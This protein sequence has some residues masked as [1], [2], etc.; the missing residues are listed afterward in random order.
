MND[1]KQLNY[2]LV[3]WKN[4]FRSFSYWP[5]VFKLLWATKKSY[6]IIILVLNII[7]GFAPVLTLLATQELIN[8]IA[9]NIG[10]SFKV[11]LFALFFLIGVSLFNTVISSILGYFD[12][13]F[14]KLLS[15]KVNELIITK[16]AGLTL[17]DFENADTQDQLQRVKN[18]ASYRPYQ[19]MKMILAIISSTVTLLSAITVLILWKWWVALILIVVPFISFFSYLKLGQEE[20][21]RMWNRAQRSRQV[22]YFSYLLTHD[23]S[24][25]EVKLNRLGQHLIDKYRVI[26]N[27]FFN[28]DRYLLIKR[29]KVSGLFQLFSMA[30]NYS[31]MLLIIWSAYLK[32]ILIGN[33][34]GL[35]QAINLTE[36]TA[37]GILQSLLSLCQ[38]NL[39]L[40]QLFTFLDLPSES[41][42]LLA[43]KARENNQKFRA[44]KEIEKIEFKNVSFRY[45]G[46]DEYA[47]KNVSFSLK[48][49]E[50]MAIVGRNGSGK[51]TIVKLLSQLYLDFEGDIFINGISIRDIDIEILRSKTGVVFQDFVHYEFPVRENIG[52]GD[53]AKLN[54]DDELIHAADQAGIKDLIQDLP[55]NLDTQLGKWFREGMQLSGGQWQRIAIA[56]AFISNSD[57]YI[58]DE[59]SSFLDPVAEK[60]VFTKFQEL[61]RGK[62]GIFISHR[63]SSVH[64]ADKILVMENGQ[65]MEE[66]PHHFLLKANGT[67]A[68]LYK[69][70]VSAFDED[71]TRSSSTSA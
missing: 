67:Y 16:A 37:Q 49:G 57:L 71:G 17:A 65:V 13:L 2:E 66:G 5:R 55:Q 47:L 63:Y 10:G 12:T 33:V 35:I 64:F 9:T 8:T 62:I 25:K 28:E 42:N 24:F 20:F 69:M 23:K 44:L 56:R 40:D 43:S 38:N 3:S 14:S 39:Y 18:E 11:I 68:N 4:I 61:I 32:E 31:I 6:F 26:I 30:V 53:I 51:S 29:M 19:V 7:M 22:W 45:N 27:D 48:K 34:V 21:L 15:N 36:G 60:E 52:F 46:T 54:Q 41:S 70:Q 58:L 1:E 50:T 59:P